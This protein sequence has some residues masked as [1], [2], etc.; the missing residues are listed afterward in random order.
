MQN[1]LLADI[2]I[3]ISYLNNLLPF[4]VIEIGIAFIIFILFMLLRKF[5]TG[6]IFNLIYKISSKRGT[7][8]DKNILL[9][10]EK[11]H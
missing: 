9:A 5:F 3:F 10:F 4:S 6:Y 7:E 11:P 1:N 2:N 8:L